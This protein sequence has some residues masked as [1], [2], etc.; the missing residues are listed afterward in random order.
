MSGRKKFFALL[1]YFVTKVRYESCNIVKKLILK[2]DNFRVIDTHNVFDTK[3]CLLRTAVFDAHVVHL[4]VYIVFQAPLILISS[5]SNIFPRTK[6][7]YH[8]YISVTEI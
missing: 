2:F 3:T 5:T 7:K 1:T 4:T 8:Y 6:F